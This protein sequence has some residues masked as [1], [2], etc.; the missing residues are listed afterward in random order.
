MKYTKTSLLIKKDLKK[1]NKII[2]TEKDVRVYRR[3]LTLK[4]SHMKYTQ[5]EIE[6]IGLEKERTTRDLIKKY[7][8]GGLNL[9]LYDHPRT[10]RPRKFSKKQEERITAIACTE[11]PLGQA[12][13]TLNLLKEVSEKNSIVKNISRE[14]VRILLASREIKPWRYKMW[15]IPN[16]DAEFISRMENVLEIYEKPYDPKEPV[17]CLDEKP[18]QLLS[19]PRP[20]ILGKIIRQDYEYQREG[21]ANAFCA[22]EPKAGKHFLLIRRTKKKKDFSYFV[23]DIVKAYPNARKIHIVM[24]NY[25]THKEDSLVETF[26]K[27]EAKKICKK[28]IFHYTP[29]HASWLNQAEIEIGMFTRGCIGKKRVK[30]IEELKIRSAAWKRN[31]NRKQIKIN[32]GFSR[33]K[34]RVKF[35]YKSGKN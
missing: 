5:K 20:E 22:I 25:G 10:G 29:K 9:A 7:K 11:P 26:G 33:R 14:S 16:V 27:K 4:V 3:A 23:R 30:T 17:V 32:W 28:I 34:A 15:C 6:D 13:W 2:K 8:T 19:S 1:I 18:V 31:M 12:R 35:K 21:V 24:D